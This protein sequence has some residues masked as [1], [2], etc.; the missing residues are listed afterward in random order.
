MRLILGRCWRSGELWVLWVVG[1]V[2]ELG[3]RID[4]I[5][6]RQLGYL[7]SLVMTIAR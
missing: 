3:L 7:G 6:C 5:D 2:V 4:K 1:E